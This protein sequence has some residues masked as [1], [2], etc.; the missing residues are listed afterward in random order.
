MLMQLHV[1]HDEQKA[2]SLGDSKS[3]PD[4]KRVKKEEPDDGEAAQKALLA[5]R[6]AT[7]NQLEKH[8]RYWYPD[9]TIVV[10]VGKM[11]FKLNGTPLAK[12]SA[13]VASAL[14]KENRRAEKLDG[15]AVCEVK[16]LAAADFEV[17]LEAFE[18]PL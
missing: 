14:D 9:G 2:D 17:F 16:G 5:A 13:V 3:Q 15:C 6:P 11:A 18:R 7:K 12:H 8:P 4:V 1:A 10:V